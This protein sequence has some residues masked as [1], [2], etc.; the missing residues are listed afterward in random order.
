MNPY[1]QRVSNDFY[2]CL[3]KVFEV[4]TDLHYRGP[5]TFNSGFDD[6]ENW[7]CDIITLVDDTN[8]VLTAQH[9][10]SAQGRSVYSLQPADFR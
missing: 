8:P 1:L 2:N 9:A 7:A 3:I 4:V 6:V 5:P 10:A